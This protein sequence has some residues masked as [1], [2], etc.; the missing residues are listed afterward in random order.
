MD[1]AG[2]VALVTGANRGLGA[3][4]AR[5]LVSRGAARVYAGA[6]DPGSITDPSLV[7]LRLDVTSPADVAAAIAAAP[8]VTLLVNNAGIAGGG[9]LVSETALETGRQQMDTNVWG[10]LALATGFAPTLAANGG[11]AIVNVLSVLSWLSL[12]GTATYSMSKAA[13][14]SLTNAL[15]QELADQGTLV[16][17]VHAGF[18]DTD[19]TA[20]ID[21]PK[22]APAD[23][24]TQILDAVA[25][26]A[27]EV[28][29]DD[30]TRHVRSTLSTPL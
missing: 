26:G 8:D 7:P 29:A 10:P 27:P 2:S 22:I 23:V 11:G 30:V 16:V 12:P 3:E 6:R 9:P 19:M 17:G 14:W 20:H 13:A 28:L 21:Q 18:I 25:S 5:Q 15:R 4:I 1:I 24:A